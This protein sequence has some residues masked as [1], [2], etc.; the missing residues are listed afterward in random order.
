[1]AFSLEIEVKKELKRAK[2]ARL[3]LTPVAIGLKTIKIVFPR[4][5]R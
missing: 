4:W 3:M 2:R 5:F 1:M